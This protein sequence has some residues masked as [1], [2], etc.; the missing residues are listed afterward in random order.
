M[1][2]AGVKRGRG[3]PRKEEAAAAEQV[4]IW[5][6]V[7]RNLP[8]LTANTEKAYSSTLGA[9]RDYLEGGEVTADA[10]RAFILERRESGLQNTSLNRHK[11]A[12]S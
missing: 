4:A 11:A 10:A 7:E 2:A 12:L 3:R 8:T 1:T 9:F 6:Q 5:V